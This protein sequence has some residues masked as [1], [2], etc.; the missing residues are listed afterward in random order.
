MLLRARVTEFVQR[1][2]QLAARHEEDNL[3]ST[4]IGF[5]SLSFSDGQLGSGV[6]LEDLKELTMSTGRIEG[7]RRGVSYDL[8]KAVSIAS[9]H[10]VA[11]YVLFRTPKLKWK[12]VLF[13][14]ST[15]A[16]RSHGYDWDDRYQMQRCAR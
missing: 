3:G 14:A 8:Y 13:T 7:W 5:P 10:V 15:L 2:V 11:S 16:I 1:F 4:A 12:E 9:W 6:I